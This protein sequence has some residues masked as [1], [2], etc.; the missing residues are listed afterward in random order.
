MIY[1]GNRVDCVWSVVCVHSALCHC[2]YRQNGD[3][4]FTVR[5]WVVGQR[6]QAPTAGETTAGHLGGQSVVQSLRRLPPTPAP[7][8][9][10]GK[11][12]RQRHTMW[13]WSIIQL[14]RGWPALPHVHDQQGVGSEWVKVH[15]GIAEEEERAGLEPGLQPQFWH[16]IGSGQWNASSSSSAQG[17]YIVHIIIIVFPTSVFPVLWI[18][19]VSLNSASLTLTLCSSHED[20]VCFVKIQYLINWSYHAFLWLWQGHLKTTEL[21]QGV[22][23]RHESL[24]NDKAKWKW[25]EVHYFNDKLEMK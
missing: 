3:C 19:L 22:W 17:V 11:S 10:E 8:V 14:A 15:G 7:L 23:P 18:C 6:H 25:K 21:W 20:R 16:F 12:E 4:Q 9:C 1:F 13:Q 2:I 24:L 5:R